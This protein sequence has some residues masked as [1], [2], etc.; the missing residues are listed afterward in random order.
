MTKGIMNKQAIG[1]FD[2]GIGGLTVAQA[3]CNALPNEDIIY[4]GDTAHLP[5]G[6]KSAEAVTQFSIG[7]A[8]FLLQE[9]C[10]MIVVACNTASAAAF[11]TLQAIYGERVLLVNVIDPMV[12]FIAQHHA[13]KKIGIIA[14]KGTVNSQVYPKKLALQGILDVHSL[15]T[16]LLVH[17]IE[18]GFSQHPGSRLLV[19]AYLSQAPLEAIEVLVLACTHYPIIKQF[20]ESYFKKPITVLDATVI[21]AA[22]VKKK[23]LAANL[24]NNQTSIGT[25]KFYV[26]DFTQAFEEVTKVFW[27][28][29]IQLEQKNIWKTLLD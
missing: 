7:I 19:E 16:P 4:Y 24:L 2:S 6:D 12:D 3:I 29:E 22:A 15:A 25:K 13:T 5:Y 14:T 10:K 11:Q 18:E 20:I 28:S 8:N 26:S 17:L 21:T 1:I 27:G 9:K 23:L